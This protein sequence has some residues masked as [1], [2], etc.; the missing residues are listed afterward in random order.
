MNNPNIEEAAKQFIEDTEMQK[1]TNLGH[2]HRQ[3]K[4][5][6]D[7]FHIPLNTGDLPSKGLFYPINTKIT[8]R[9]ATVGEIRHFSTIDETDVFSVTDMSNYI[10]EKCAK[11]SMPGKFD[12]SYKDLKEVDRLYII[13]AI[14]ELTFKE[15]ENKIF[16]KNTDVEL[17]K[18]ILKLRSLPDILATRYDGEERCFKFQF[19]NS[20]TIHKLYIPSVGTSSFL[21]DYVKR[22]VQS[23]KQFNQDFMKYAP[24]LL[25]DHRTLND[26][27]YEKLILDNMTWDV[28][29]ISLYDK[30]VSDVLKDYLTPYAEYEGVEYAIEF[31]E[32]SLK[33]LFLISD[34]F[35]QLV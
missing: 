22:K 35:G 8:I 3:D 20:Q 1:Q 21:L 34:I 27:S 24:F 23:G 15:G 12:A 7:D 16:I 25:G 30:L 13:L 32:N 10:V 9:A 2:V 26:K 19:A 31:S 33:S 11:I 17:T 28:N 4:T 5:L 14:R 29:T 6:L 18:D